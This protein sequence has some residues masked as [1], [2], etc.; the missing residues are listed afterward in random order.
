MNKKQYKWLCCPN[1]CF[2]LA[3]L[4]ES[5]SA[6]LCRVL[7]LICSLLLLFFRSLGPHLPILTSL[8]IINSHLSW[9]FFYGRMKTIKQSM[10]EK[11]LEQPW[12][13]LFL[14]HQSGTFQLATSLCQ[15]G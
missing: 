7:I 10:M 11:W 12:T 1:V 13:K 6:S 8:F 5:R 4:R 3:I 15:R 9:V 2:I 14:V